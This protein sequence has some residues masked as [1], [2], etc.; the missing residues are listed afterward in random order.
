MGT[1]LRTEVVE[2]KEYHYGYT[3][4]MKELPSKKWFGC[5]MKGNVY[6]QTLPKQ[7]SIP[8]MI[9]FGRNRMKELQEEQETNGRGIQQSEYSIGTD[10]RDDHSLGYVE[11][12]Y[13]PV[14]DSCS[15]GTGEEGNETCTERREEPG[16]SGS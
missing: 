11:S 15:V 14:G 13:T 5:I 4:E 9:E 8:A 1:Q 6:I 7:E 3:L 12:V 16:I 10:V 2:L